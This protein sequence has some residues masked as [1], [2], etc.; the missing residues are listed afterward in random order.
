[1]KLVF[2]ASAR[3]SPVVWSNTLY[4]R[5]DAAGGLSVSVRN[6]LKMNILICCCEFL[7]YFFIF[8]KFLFEFGC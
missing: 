3:R 4:P 2:L 6:F 1:M 8:L 7:F 5:T